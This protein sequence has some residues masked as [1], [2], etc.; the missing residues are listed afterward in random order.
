MNSDSF[1]ALVGLV[2]FI[3]ATVLFAYSFPF[4]RTTNVNEPLQTT[5][6][7]TVVLGDEE[8]TTVSQAATESTTARGVTSS[9]ARRSEATAP[10]KDNVPE[11]GHVTAASEA[12]QP[13]VSH[14]RLEANVSREELR[15]T[16]SLNL[17]VSLSPPA[18]DRECLATVRLSA[19]SFDTDT[20][21]AQDV[22]VR[23]RKAHR[24]YWILVPKKPG[25]YSIS[26]S[27][28]KHHKLIE[29]KVNNE[30]GVSPATAKF[31]SLVGWIVA[32]L[33][34]APWLVTR[35]RTFLGW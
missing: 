14:C 27:T 32:T 24:L 35:L 11:E 2:L 21:M 31:A 10:D 23:G 4:A 1:A 3:F 22:R 28:E 30:W 16:T 15:V 33:L 5:H 26:V 9:N 25:T 19:P 8:R 13:P 12:P 29:I 7:R 34:A 6:E 17:V 18:S 20:E